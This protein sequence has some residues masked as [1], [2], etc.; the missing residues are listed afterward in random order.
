[1]AIKRHSAS[2]NVVQECKAFLS[3]IGS[4][5]QCG[6]PFLSFTVG[7]RLGDSAT[8][9]FAGCRSRILRILVSYCWAAPGD[10]ESPQ[11]WSVRG[12]D[13]ET[14]T[15]GYWPGNMPPLSF[16]SRC[17]LCWG[18]CGVGFTFLQIENWKAR[19]GISGR[20]RGKRQFHT[21]PRGSRFKGVFGSREKNH[22]LPLTAVTA[23]K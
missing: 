15:C 1:M 17:Y 13:M 4:T 2:Q 12:H 16:S 8:S 22:S 21:C 19:S 20:M 14:T 6:V 23:P 18:A 3:F 10:S 9:R 5:P 11:G 7:R